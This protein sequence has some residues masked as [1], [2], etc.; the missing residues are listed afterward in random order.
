[1]QLACEDDRLIMVVSPGKT[2]NQPGLGLSALVI[3]NDETRTRML[4]MMADMTTHNPFSL[5]AWEAAYRHGAAWRSA[6]MLYLRDSRDQILR[7]I[8][9]HWPQVRPISPQGT[10]L[11]WLDCRAYELN[12]TALQDLFI[13]K[14]RVGLSPGIQF[15]SAGRGFMRLNLATPRQRLLTA[16]KTST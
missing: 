10:V 7:A 1:M 5:T 13:E 16:I 15:G 6:L 12:D 14:Y 2:F 4:S 8:H 3:I 9:Q 11:M